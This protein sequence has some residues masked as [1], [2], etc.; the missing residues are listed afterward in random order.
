[1]TKIRMIL[2][3]FALSFWSMPSQSQETWS[4]EQAQIVAANHGYAQAILLADLDRLMSYYAED[5]V[6]LP[7]SAVPIV[8]KEA[9]RANWAD[10]LGQ[11]DVIEAVSTFDEIIV[12]GNWAYARGRYSGR[13]RPANGGKE[14][15]E[16][17]SFS[18]MWRRESDGSWK[19]ARD[20]WNSG[21]VY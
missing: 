15:E 3:L 8:G 6:L 1:M 12:L 19:I 2:L 7:P 4:T 17:L 16:R 5:A 11:F 21:P 20:M 9:I 14:I 10:L 13:S 18:G